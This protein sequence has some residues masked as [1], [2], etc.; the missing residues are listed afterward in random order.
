MGGIG[1]D[2]LSMNFDKAAHQV[3]LLY[4]RLAVTAPLLCCVFGI[5]VL[6]APAY[7]FLEAYFNEGGY[8]EPTNPGRGVAYN[9]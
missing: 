8:K 7:T 2:L 1:I 9:P 4:G 5:V 6:A 3:G